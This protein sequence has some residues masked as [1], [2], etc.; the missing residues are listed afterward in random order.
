MCFKHCVHLQG[1]LEHF[2][3]IV[4]SVGSGGTMCGITIGN[5]LTGSKVR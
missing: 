1:V 3:D 5:Y 2:D 4:L